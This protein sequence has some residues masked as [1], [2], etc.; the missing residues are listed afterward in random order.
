MRRIK[1]DLAGIAQRLD[2]L[3][4]NFGT[5]VQELSE[6]WRDAKGRSFLQRHAAEVQPT[7]NQLVAAVNTSAELFERIARKLDDTQQA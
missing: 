1:H 4:S 3:S 6:V 2:R 7:L 5:E